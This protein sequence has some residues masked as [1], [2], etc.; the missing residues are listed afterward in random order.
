MSVVKTKYKL[1]IP[2]FVLGWTMIGWPD[3][4]NA[5]QEKKVMVLVYRQAQAATQIAGV[6]FC[7]A[8]LHSKV[9]SH[10]THA[11]QAE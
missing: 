3:P 1:S 5:T 7:K 10:M 6:K 9:Q 11:I 8:K 4:C 2:W